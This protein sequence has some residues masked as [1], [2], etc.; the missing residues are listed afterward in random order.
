MTAN[1]RA[2]S[3]RLH[4]S[5]SCPNT[6]TSGNSSISPEPTE[7]K[8]RTHLS[9]R[10]APHPQFILVLETHAPPLLLLPH[11]IQLDLDVLLEIHRDAIDERIRLAFEARST[12]E[13]ALRN[14]ARVSFGA[15]E[16]AAIEAA[17]LEGG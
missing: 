4:K 14:D 9:K 1:E 2:C 15:E 16:G 13:R 5:Y 3:I 10:P 7:P 17:E 12:P 8:L 11:L 6:C